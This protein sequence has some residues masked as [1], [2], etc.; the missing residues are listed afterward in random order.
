MR[1]LFERYRRHIDHASQGQALAEFAL[2]SIVLLF[3]FGTALDL[4]RVFYADI[5]VEN[6]AR[7]G[8][9]QAARTPDSFTNG[10]CDYATNKIGCAAINESRGSFVSISG[11][12]V[13]AQCESLGGSVVSCANEP[14]PSTRS[15]VT[16]STQFDLLTPIL[17]VFFGGQTINL[18][19]TAASDQESLPPGAF[20]TSTPIPTPTGGLP[21]ATASATATATASASATAGPTAT[22]SAGP[23]AV[24][25]QTPN[26]NCTPETVAPDLVTG[27]AGGAETVA[28]ARQ[29]WFVG[30]GFTG[31]LFPA[32]GH[33]N[34]FVMAQWAN[35]SKTIPL[36]PG[37]CYPLTQQV[38]LDYQ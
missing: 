5:T 24:P 17:A 4:G 38:W 8:A 30:S 35:A 20:A 36:V 29:E 2:I 21:T 23:T 1:Q 31:L 22:A 32:N 37:A 15:R 6:A 13:D 14:Q 9:L 26:I 27:L 10:A 16:V 11:A 7:A 33:D 19:A 18:S 12:D 3:L 28:E 25:T 34:K